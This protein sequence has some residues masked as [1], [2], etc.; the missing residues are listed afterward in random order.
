[1]ALEMNEV[2]PIDTHVFNISKKY[3]KD[4]PKEYGKL[5]KKHFDQIQEF[6]VDI[7]GEYAGWAQSTLFTNQV[8]VLKMK[9]N[10]LLQYFQTNFILIFS[11]F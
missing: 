2:V 1:M 8:S 9:I 3:L 6:W 10:Q 7:F 5:N 4:L 11:V